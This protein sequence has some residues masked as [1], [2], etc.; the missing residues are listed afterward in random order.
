MLSLHTHFYSQLIDTLAE[1]VTL[2]Y[3]QK[4]IVGG[5]LVLDATPEMNIC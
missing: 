1:L 3:D 5:Y 4:N 2:S